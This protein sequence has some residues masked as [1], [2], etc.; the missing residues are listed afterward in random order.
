MV[1]ETPI[2]VRPTEVDTFGHVNNAKYLEYFEWARFDWFKAIGLTVEH[3][4]S[5]LAIVVANVNVNFRREASVDERLVVRTR[6]AS[7]G[8]SS[9]KFAQELVNERGE[10]ITDAETTGVMFDTQTRRST[11]IPDDLA[12]RL[13]SALV[14]FPRPQTGTAEAS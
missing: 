6:L 10:V 4:R 5:G 3:F 14:P 7:R 13:D 9:L 1:I 8:R 12:H 2:V 11:P